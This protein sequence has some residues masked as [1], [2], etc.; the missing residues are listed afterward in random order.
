[1][2]RDIEKELVTKKHGFKFQGIVTPADDGLL[3]SLV[4]PF[5]E[6]YSD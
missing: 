3:S 4:G 6:K 2:M 1:M 5:V